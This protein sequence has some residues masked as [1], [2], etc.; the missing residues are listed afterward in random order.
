[1]AG[2]HPTTRLGTARRGYR[3][4]FGRF[5]NQI[6]IRLDRFL[7]DQTRER[8]PEV[9]GRPEL[10]FH[11]IDQRI[12]RQNDVPAGRSVELFDA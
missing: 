2:K 6:R 11:H 8:N 10:D 12:E 7:H 5:R 1:M 3:G 4:G 9:N